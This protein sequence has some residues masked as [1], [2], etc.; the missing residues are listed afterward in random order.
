MPAV[1]VWRGRLL[2]PLFSGPSPESAGTISAVFHP[3]SSSL[4]SLTLLPRFPSPSLGPPF[5]RRRLPHRPAE[6]SQRGPEIASASQP[7][8]DPSPFP[9][10]PSPWRDVTF[11]GWYGGAGGGGSTVVQATPRGQSDGDRVGTG[12]D[13]WPSPVTS[14]LANPE[15]RADLERSSGRAGTTWWRTD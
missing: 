10:L 8:T 4:S 1:S 5:A 13:H 14:A 9:P 15:C 2:T 6:R 7:T 11:P 12:P 3:G